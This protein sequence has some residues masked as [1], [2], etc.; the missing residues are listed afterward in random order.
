VAAQSSVG[1]TARVLI[2]LL[3]AGV[4]LAVAGGALACGSSGYTY[5]GLAS[6]AK[7]YGVGARVTAIGAPSV[8]GANGHVAGWV[9]VGGPKQGPNGRDEWIQ[10]GFSGFRGSASS[11]LY[12]EVTRAGSAPTYHEVESNLPPGTTRRL[13]VLEL[14]DRPNWWRVWVDGRAVSDAIFLPGSH[15]TWPGVAT[16]ES[17]SDSKSGACNAFGYRFDDIVVAQEAGGAWRT[18]SNALPIRSG[19]NKLLRPS[20]SSFEALAGNVPEV[21][22]QLPKPQ[23]PAPSTALVAGTRS[24]ASARG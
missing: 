23:E 18:L 2:G 5:A 22:P 21:T 9:G 7:T 14:G 12:F 3:V 11:D 1:R 8:S 24:T 19:V 15:G 10:V 4:A 16:A 17:W 13:A 6:P 20:S